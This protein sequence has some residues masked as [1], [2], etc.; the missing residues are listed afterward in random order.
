[1][2][3]P[4]KWQ[5]HKRS[6]GQSAAEYAV[7]I[8]VVSAALIAMGDYVRRAIQANL[9]VTEDRINAEAITAPG[10]GP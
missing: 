6:W 3:R 2:L 1:M 5:R 7:T 8:V 9:K 10:P 4:T